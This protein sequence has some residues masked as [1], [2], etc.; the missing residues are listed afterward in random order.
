M[1]IWNYDSGG[2]SA[3]PKIYWLAGKKV[4]K[5]VKW[6]FVSGCSIENYAATSMRKIAKDPSVQLNTSQYFKSYKSLDI[7]L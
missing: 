4:G 1:G 2:R 7:E 3:L 6:R 5:G